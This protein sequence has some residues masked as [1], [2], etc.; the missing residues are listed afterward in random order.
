MRVYSGSLFTNSNWFAFEDERIVNEHSTG[1]IASSSPNIEGHADVD[2]GTDDVVAEEDEDL[3]DTAISK[4]PES[5]PTLEGDSP[6][7]IGSYKPPEWVEWR[8][9]S[10]SVELPPTSNPADTSVDTPQC[11]SKPNGELLESE[12]KTDDIV[13]DKAESSVDGASDTCKTDGESSPYSIES[14]K[15][16][17]STEMGEGNQRTRELEEEN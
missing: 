3:A 2:G 15:T 1:A 16:S 12:A 14:I 8:E 13:P 9:S 5:K 4:S 10:D 11:P 17:Q 6:E 7:T